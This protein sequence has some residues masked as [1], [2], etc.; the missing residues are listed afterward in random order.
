MENCNL[1]LM[2]NWKHASR[3]AINLGRAKEQSLRHMTQICIWLKSEWKPIL[4]WS[5]EVFFKLLFQ[6]P[7]E[8][9]ESCNFKT[10][11]ITFIRL[12]AFKT[13]IKFPFSVTEGAKVV[14]TC[15]QIF[16]I[17]RFSQ[18]HFG[19][20]ANKFQ[21]WI[22]H[23]LS[24]NSLAAFNWRAFGTLTNYCLRPRIYQNRRREKK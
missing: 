4:M 14:Q 15:K 17:C 16:K 19:G 8:N 13:F 22:S 20:D 3:G 9:L 21:Q 5:L 2:W 24:F 18:R 10:K 1:R 12:K 6:L 11:V 23:S 7:S